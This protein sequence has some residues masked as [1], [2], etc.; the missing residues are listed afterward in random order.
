MQ[1]RIPGVFKVVNQHAGKF[2][3]VHHDELMK[4]FADDI[5]IAV[6]ESPTST[7]W[8][9]QE[10]NVPIV[11]PPAATSKNIPYV[12]IVTQTLVMLIVMALR[13]SPTQKLE[14]LCFLLLPW[15]HALLPPH[16]PCHRH[17][18][19]KLKLRPNRNFNLLRTYL[20]L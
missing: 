11:V 5:L 15:A 2:V 13:L 20:A 9:F 7:E 6:L 1:P 14:P 12:F 8:V 10:P 16:Q 17:C 19:P 18:P 3:P 4:S